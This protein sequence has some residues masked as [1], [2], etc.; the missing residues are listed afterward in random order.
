VQV[1]A[2]P[3]H[4]RVALQDIW[5]E[6]LATGGEIEILETFMLWEGGVM[7]RLTIE[8]AL[9]PIEPPMVPFV[10][11]KYWPYIGKTIE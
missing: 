1:A 4:R 3:P 9:S 6:R 2:L 5:A 10:Q 8:A 7:V 11:F